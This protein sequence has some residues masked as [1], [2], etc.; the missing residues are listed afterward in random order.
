MPRPTPDL[1]GQVFGR[2]TVVERVAPAS[3]HARWHC[4]CDCGNEKDVNSSALREGKTRSCG[5]LRSEVT[6]ARNF[7]H[8]QAPR[9][10]GV[11]KG[12]YIRQGLTVQDRKSGSYGS[13]ASMIAR[14]A[15]PRHPRF[16]DWGGRGITVCPEWRLFENFLAD[17]GEKPPGTTIERRENAL[18]YSP[19]NCYWA[20]RAEQ[21]RNKR[22]TKLTAAKILE[23]RDLL[24]A[25]LAVT[26]AAAGAGIERHVAGVIASTILAL[27]SEPHD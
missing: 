5:C 24:D 8:G 2:L 21:N 22:S 16:A 7:R 12:S 27:R 10:G 11:P 13:W 9:P 25:G 3:G 23:I 18:G 15:N 17:M 4:L 20:S 6:A 1:A 26:A 19:G 14:T